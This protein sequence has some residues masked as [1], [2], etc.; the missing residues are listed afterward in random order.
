MEK[1]KPAHKIQYGLIQAAIWVN[2]TKDGS[3]FYNVTFSRAYKNG[4]NLKNTTSFRK[5]D[6]LSVA[7]LADQAHSWISEQ[8]ATA[9]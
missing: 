9:A 6:L 1:Q 3:T 7:K 4:N 8:D 2:T 5:V